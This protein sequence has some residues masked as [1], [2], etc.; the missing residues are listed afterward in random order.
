MLKRV[1][2]ITG[3][4]LVILLGWVLLTAVKNYI[5]PTSNP[6]RTIGSRDGFF[7]GVPDDFLRRLSFTDTRAPARVDMEA[8]GELSPIVGL[9][10]I[11]K[12]PAS[13]RTNDLKAEYLVL[14]ANPNN[15]RPINIS[16]WS[17]QSM[18]S[19][20]WIGLPQGVEVFAVGEVNELQDIYLRPGE[21]AIIATRRSPV[22]L[23]FHVNRCSGFLEDTQ[24]F[25]P[26]LRT[27]CI[28]PTELLPATVENIRTYGD[29]CVTFTHNLRSCTYVTADTRGVD[30]LSQACRDRIQPRLTQ[31][32]CTSIHASDADFYAPREWRIF[33]NQD[34]PL[35]REDY[36]VVRLLDEEHRTIDVINY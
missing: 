5:T 2:V 34:A 29:E 33:L 14:Y 20:E 1:L 18:V 31:N 12:K 15:A 7:F 4:F 36:E 8:L 13:L 16:N 25:Q 10:E 24:D 21:R 11:E 28:V 6:E 9:V 30:T 23:S 35:W 17:L 3:I 32:Y 22:G 26:P 27:R 19:D